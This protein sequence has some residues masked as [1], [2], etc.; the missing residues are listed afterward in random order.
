[1]TSRTLLNLTLAIA[2]ASLIALAIFKPGSKPVTNE[3]PLTLLKPDDVQ[4]IRVHLP[5]HTDIELTKIDGQWTMLA[6]FSVPAN[7]QRIAQLLK[8]TSAKILATYTIDKT[9]TTQKGY[10]RG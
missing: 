4:K 5:G 10:G 6:P 7:Q 9:D 1:M 2:L 3:E 8:I